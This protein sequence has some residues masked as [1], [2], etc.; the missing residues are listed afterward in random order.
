MTIC[1][2]K[3]QFKYPFSKFLFI[4]LHK[5]KNQS[6]MASS[7]A[8]NSVFL[9]LCLGLTFSTTA[10]GGNFNT[11]FNILFGDKMANIQDNGNSMTLT[12]DEYSGSGI[13]T[14]NEY[15]FGRFDM[16]IKLVPGNSAG[17]VTAF[18]VC[19]LFKNYRHIC[20]L[21]IHIINSYKL[22]LHLYC[23]PLYFSKRD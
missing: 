18:Y 11:D 10:F 7:Y 15:L 17:T 23:K 6:I 12:M 14:N 9:L 5:V 22:Q 20:K 21:L 4:N 3:L 8:N 13:G 2:Y 19:T 16:Q 1:K